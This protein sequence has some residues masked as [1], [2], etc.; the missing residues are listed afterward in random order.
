MT[1]CDRNTGR[2]LLEGDLPPV[3]E[4]EFVRHLESCGRC[5]QWLDEEAGDEE[6]WQAARDLLSTSSEIIH[7][8]STTL[9]Q[10]TQILPP[11]SP[12][13]ATEV[14]SFD[15]AF[16]S[17]TDDPAFIGRIGNYE[18]SGVIGRGG[19]GVVFKARDRSLNRNVAIK[20]LAPSLASIGAARRRFAREA[21]AMAAIS[22]EH[23]VPIYCVDDHQGLPYFA[24][25]YI[26][27]GTL[28]SR[29][30]EQGPLDIISTVRIALQVAAAL[31]AAH[32][33]GL[34]HRDI[35]PANIL[36]DPGVDRVRVVDFGLARIS[37]DASYTRS[38]LLAGTPQFMAP[39]QVR[40]E[41][42]DARA[43]L[44]SLGSVIY[45]MCTGHA[46]FRAETVYAVMQRIVHDSPRPVR[47]QAEH[48]PLWLEQFIGRLLSK[49]CDQRFDSAAE[50]VQLLEQELSHLQGS[51]SNPPPPR[52][53]TKVGPS[54][55]RVRRRLI[56]SVAVAVIACLGVGIG[57]VHW[58]QPPNEERTDV[59]AA[60]VPL[61]N[62]DDVH[63][64]MQQAASME[65]NLLQDSSSETYDPWSEEIRH[66]RQRMA[67]V[68]AQFP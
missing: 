62:R 68:D 60:D 13:T 20:V 49:S 26:A 17:P 46:P 8:P 28:E 12:G 2:R 53:W 41:A 56:I 66:V 11:Q 45:A 24:M 52:P 47:E 44:F 43:D 5:R 36:L 25:E 23:V 37:N 32:G 51:G 15:L 39:E 64:A 18:V 19:M 65:A 4:S 54:R 58:G 48:V 40:G 29:L 30:R 9:G 34:V 31:S 6:T 16:L 55:K 10:D 63:E 59:P 14:A 42:C 61:W 1:S 50:V 57:V 35:K 27:G 38:G 67:E 33:C 7:W 22:H 3:D 21:R